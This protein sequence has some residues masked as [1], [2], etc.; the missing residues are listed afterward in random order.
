MALIQCK[1]CGESVSDK[2]KNCPHCGG[3]LIE[4]NSETDR[5]PEAPL[6]CEECNTE[7]PQGATTCP[8]CG[9]P[10]SE[11]ATE[12]VAQK[13]EVTAVNLQMKKSTKKYVVIAAIAVIV[14][15][16][17][18]IIASNMHKK[19]L[20]KQAAELSAEYAANIEL[21]SYTM[22]MGAIE[23]E[24]A[25]NLINKVWRNTI[26][27]ERDS[28]TDKYTHTREGKGVWF[29]DFND[30]LRSLFADSTFQGK[31][32]SIEENQD[33]VAELMKQLKNPPTEHEE[34]YEALKEYYD[35][36]LELTNLATNPSGNLATYSSNF[37]E[38]DSNVLKYYNAMSLYFES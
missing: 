8:K 16:I 10:V 33:S 17:I 36:Y 6:I 34:A 28:E 22:L 7:I 37:N 9:C 14:I 25:A 3:L 30:A 27:K 1:Y 11:R 4:D 35:A 24:D 15:A 26:Y 12:E 2:A 29:D 32:T 31:I 13:V 21:T 18:G 5:I 20:E 19:N 38:A 23:A